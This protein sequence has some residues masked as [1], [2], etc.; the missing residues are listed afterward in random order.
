MLLTFQIFCG[1]FVTKSMG[2]VCP[3]LSLS[4]S[5]ALRCLSER[6]GVSA[7]MAG[8]V[9][10]GFFLLSSTL[11]SMKVYV[12]GPELCGSALG[13]ALFTLLQNLLEKRFYNN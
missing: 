9:G 1:N 6:S 7:K 3:A 11:W 10:L 13:L 4:L 12:C 2:R 5:T 8:P